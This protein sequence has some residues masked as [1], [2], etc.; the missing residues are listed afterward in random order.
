M[1]SSVEYNS[2]LHGSMTVTYRAIDRRNLA[3]C[4]YHPENLERYS[5]KQRAGCPSEYD[6]CR[7]I[8]AG[9]DK[10]RAFPRIE[11]PVALEKAL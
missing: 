7:R 8:A 3:E 11:W 9:A 1:D 6:P 2:V 5:R 10:C 4:D